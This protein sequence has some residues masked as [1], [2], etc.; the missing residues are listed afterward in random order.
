MR[1][2]TCVAISKQTPVGSASARILMF[3]FLSLLGHWLHLA[4][5]TLGYITFAV[6]MLAL[7]DELH[8]W[9]TRGM[10]ARPRPK[11][12]GDVAR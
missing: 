1:P 9:L 11:G 6:I 8:A 2:G 12:Q 4:I 3:E 10:S 5:C 7:I